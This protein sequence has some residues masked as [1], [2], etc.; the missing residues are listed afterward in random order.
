MERADIVVGILCK[1][2]E[3]TILHVMNVVNEGLHRYF[4]EY[5]KAMVLSDG[6][7]SDRTLE[8]ATLFQPYSGI[9]K[10]VTSDMERGGK[11]GGVKT[12]LKIARDMDAKVVLLLDGDLL[13]IKPEWIYELAAPILY[14]RADLIVPYYIRDKYDGVITNNLVYPFTRALYGMDIRQPIAGEY[15]ISKRLYEMLLPHPLFPGDFGV[16]IFIVT[17]AAANRMKVMEGIFSLK[18]HESTTHYLEPERNVH[19]GT[20]L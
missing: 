8:M 5:E 1:N 15:G 10:V 13:S 12:I 18:I 11:G 17:S 14:G 16:D 6:F 9:K 19:T 7:S 20:T 3:S 2:V 4:S